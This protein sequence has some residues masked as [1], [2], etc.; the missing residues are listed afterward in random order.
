MIRDPEPLD[1]DELER[2]RIRAAVRQ[3]VPGQAI[4]KETWEAMGYG[5]TGR[6]RRNLTDDRIGH[7]PHPRPETPTT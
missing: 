3:V 7:K 6:R 5:L 2:E 4:T 1:D